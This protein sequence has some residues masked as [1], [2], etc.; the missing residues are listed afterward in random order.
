[1]VDI[2]GLFGQGSIGQ[3]FL[4]YNVGQSVAQTAL[5]PFL[6]QL[7]EIVWRVDPSLP[8]PPQ[9]CAALVARG[10][11]SHESGANEAKNSGI[12]G[13]RF[14]NLITAAQSA[15]SLAEALELHRRGALPLGQPGQQGASVYGAIKDSGIRDEWAEIVVKLGTQIPSVAEVMDA[16]LQGQIE[17]PEARKRYLEAG[18]DPTWFQTSFNANGT[19]PTPVELGVMANRGIIPWDGAGP[20]AVSYHQGFLEGPW[21]NKWEA[22]LRRLAE[23]LPPARTVTAMVHEGSIS[24]QEALTLWRKE[25]LSPELAAAYLK[26]AHHTSTAAHKE[27]AKADILSL[28]ADKLIDEPQA[29]KLLQELGYTGPVANLVLKVT[30]THRAH[31]AV[32]SAVSRLR[33]LYTSRKITKAATLDALH[34]LGVPATETSELLQIWDIQAAANIRQLTEGQIVSAFSKEVLTQ[35]EATAELIAI[36][37]TPYDAWVLLSTRH[38][39]KLPHQPA[40]GAGGIGVLP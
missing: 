36:N 10:L 18:G 40:K 15:P 33:T 26:S 13:D 35:E 12:N 7:Q 31:A 14:N 27:L 28:Y 30:D 11:I 1:M 5:S 21:R 4:L 24:D 17:E 39:E 23:Y 34:N 32:N 3:Q 38:G 29:S 16:W 20:H 22:A 19:A 2:G 8:I 9:T 6:Q 37:Y 25:G